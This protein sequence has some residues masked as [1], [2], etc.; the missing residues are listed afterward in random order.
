MPYNYPEIKRFK[1]LYLQANS[2][3]LPD[4][5]LEECNN[6]VISK[7]GIV[8]KIR[9]NY[10]Y[11]AGSA[12]TLKSL[13]MY[14]GRLF[15]VCTDK[16]ISITDTG[17]HPNETGSATTVTAA[18]TFAVTGT[19]ICR[20][21][22]QNNNTYMTTD[23][24][25]MKIES[26][27]SKVTKAGTPPALDLGGYFTTTNG[28][29]AGDNQYGWRVVFGRRD[30]NSNL[31]LGAPSDYL[32]MTN[33]R[34]DATWTRSGVSPNWVIA[35]NTGTTSHKLTSGMTVTVASSSVPAL[36]GDRASI[37]V[38]GTNTF[39]FAYSSAVD[40]G[41]SGDLDFYTTRN[42]R[43]EFSL[44]AEITDI[45][46]GYFYQVYRTSP[47][48]STSASPLLDFALIDE[49]LL[50]SSDLTAR[51][52]TYFDATANILRGAELYT[53]PGSR[54]GEAQS[55][56]QPPIC[57]DLCLFKNHVFYTAAKTKSYLDMM[58]VDV[59][60]LTDTG[61]NWD[62]IE[63]DNGGTVRRYVARSGPVNTTVYGTAA[64]TST[65]TI[66]SIAHGITSGDVV[67]VNTLS[68]TVP[69]GFYTATYATADTFTIS[70][71]T[72]TATEV[73][74]SIVKDSS[75][76]YLFKRSQDTSVAIQIRETAISLVKAIN[77]DPNMAIYANYAST[78]TGL[79]G[80]IRFS[81]INFGSIFKLRANGNTEGQAFSPA[82]TDSFLS[83]TTPTSAS[84]ENYSGFYSSKIGEPEAVPLANFYPIG[85]KNKR[86]LRMIA[87]RDSV[88]AIKE[89]GIYRIDGDSIFNFSSTS[90]DTTTICLAP[91]SVD[92]I[93]N[94]VVFLSNQGVCLA[95]SNAVRI[96]SRDIETPIKA[97][98]G[99]SDLAAQTAGVAYE[100]ERLY[101][102]TTI[103][104]GSTVAD[105]TYVYNTLSD[106]WSTCDY[107]ILSG[108]VGTN[109][110][111]FWID[112][113]NTIKKER[114]N[115]NRIDF[116]GQN[117]V[118]NV[119]SVSTD[120]KSAV[121]S[122]VAAPIVGDVLILGNIVNRIKSV[123]NVSTNL[124]NV[125]FRNPTDLVLTDDPMLYRAYNTTIKT[126]P[127]HAGAIGRAKQFAQMQLHL[128]DNSVRNL[129][130][131]FGGQA[132]GSSPT[133][134]WSSEPIDT[135][136][137]WGLAPW[138]LFGW[139][140]TDSTDITYKTEQAPVVRVYIPLI[141]Q[142]S[143]FIQPIINHPNAAEEIN[144]QALTYAVRGYNER[145]TK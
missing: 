41:A 56:N 45:N 137:G 67:Y 60:Y 86:L 54:E 101:F 124:W 4:G 96:V 35:V 131:T 64:G 73:E 25:V 53:N 122:T 79:P 71:P 11:L 144:L 59:T 87:L 111:L 129:N 108:R 121:I 61:P 69:N 119:N 30:A 136:P 128:R 39:T 42:A 88:L 51:F 72:Y 113:N 19:R 48:G 8:S 20:T 84:D 142:R 68:G 16:L 66:T 62:W 99:S 93:N 89:D 115:F 43:L 58:V 107:R 135:T 127:F 37:T 47:S 77:R 118:A 130:I 46:D 123:T 33:A 23:G 15:G 83:A 36:D 120:K 95:T 24:G 104:P 138:G 139:G 13:F 125:A 57:D 85:S 82:L 17:T 74:Y 110:T 132:Y 90:L 31:L 55:N 80:Q 27:T 133:V 76:Y 117:Y 6:A 116:C 102:L 105:Q 65:V 134:D 52:A 12:N 28:S 40:P 140:Q 70:A 7:D 14:K 92:S 9:G 29:I 75:G 44:P 21:L 22:E 50:T 126:S 97:V 63:I 34:V 98:L 1:G 49:V 109:D 10:D 94:Q 5:A 143:T 141:A 2:F 114:K 26:L 91:N 103:K 18:S 112:R 78:N 3:D 100:S 38:T 81:S 145:V 32:F 106:G